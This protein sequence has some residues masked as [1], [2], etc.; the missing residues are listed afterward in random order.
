MTDRERVGY[1]LFD[2][3]FKP[4]GIAERADKY[5]YALRVNGQPVYIGG[6]SPGVEKDALQQGTENHIRFGLENL[7]FTGQFE[8]YEK[9]HLVVYFLNGTTVVFRQDLDR[10]YIALRDA[11]EIPPIQS[12][13]GA[14][15]WTGKYIVPNNENKYEILLASAVCGDP[16]EKNCADRAVYAKTQFDK[17]GMKFNGYPVVMVVRPPLRKPPAYGLALGLVQPTSQVE[18]TFDVKAASQGCHW[19][20][21]YIGKGQAGRLIRPDLNRYEVA[22]RAYMSCR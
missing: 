17:A 1:T 10:D 8:G 11:A 7:N 9:L 20:A 22:K 21:S 6:L 5:Y 13:V 19:A 2:V 15:Q 3:S 14:F 16:P 12:E 4:Q 18:F